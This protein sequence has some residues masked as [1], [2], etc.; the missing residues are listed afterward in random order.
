MESGFVLSED[1]EVNLQFDAKLQ[2]ILEKHETVV[3]LSDTPNVSDTLGD[4]AGSCTSNK[5]VS[6][7]LESQNYQWLYTETSRVLYVY[8]KTK[9][10]KELRKLGVKAVDLCLSLGIRGISVFTPSSITIS[11]SKHFLQSMILWNYKFEMK[12]VGKSQLLSLMSFCFEGERDASDR[13]EL[14]FYVCA[15]KSTLFV[16]DL[17]NTRA[18]VATPEYM[19]M[20]IRHVAADNDRV[21]GLSVIKGK[22]LDD[23]GL[24][25]FYNVGKGTY[26]A[27]S[28]TFTLYLLVVNAL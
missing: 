15:T 21:T 19:E 7:D 13:K 20:I 1:F 26:P 9:S 22:E 25:V 4:K 23:Q 14:E 18:N 6:Q 10:P 3:V 24:K 27:N 2:D 28:P 11:E 8:T 5:L 12:T 16:R 17:V